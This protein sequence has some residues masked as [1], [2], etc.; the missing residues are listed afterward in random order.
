[1][2]KGQLEKEEQT[3]NN[4]PRTVESLCPECNKAV[5]AII[6]INDNNVV[7][8]KTCQKHGFFQEILSND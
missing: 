2:T 4:F 1:M 8:E 5:K 7:M 6:K 3:Y